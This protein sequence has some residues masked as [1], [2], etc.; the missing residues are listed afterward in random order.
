MNK[1][2]FINILPR[3]DVH[4]FTRDTVLVPVS[5]FINDNL[6]LGN[7]KIVIVHGLGEGVLK[8]AI[9]THFSHDRRVKKIYGDCFNLGITIIEL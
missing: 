5:E 7:N 8:K 3:L 2:P 9:N 1:D 4:G 6:K